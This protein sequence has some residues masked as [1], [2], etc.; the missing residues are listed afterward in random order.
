MTKNWMI[1][2]PR[3][4][5]RESIEEVKILQWI[6]KH[7]VHKWIVAKERGTFGYDHWQIRI[8]TNLDFAQLKD[9]WG[10]NAH[11][12]E[13]SDNY[14]YERKECNF[15]CSEDTPGILQCRYGTLRPN[16]NRILE[17]I[18]S[19]GDRTITC[20]V[21]ARGNSG[22]SHLCRMCYERGIG[23]YVPPTINTPQGIIQFV[24]SGYR[25]EEIIFIDIP[26]STRWNPNL[27]VAVE[28]I[29][30]GLV[31][32]ARYNSKTRNIYGVKVA[33]M[34][35]TKPNVSKLS[36]DRWDLIDQKGRALST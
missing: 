19:G 18:R 8:Q 12:E 23:M 30:D 27:Y 13:A 29:K 6:L 24:A 33:V 20:I 31:Y 35:N 16:Q 11:I 2:K 9:E 7:D 14:E 25:G 3:N 5:D 32:D 36:A 15:I 17:R 4:K 22:K 21:D 28:T 26:R 10:E 1:T 34:C